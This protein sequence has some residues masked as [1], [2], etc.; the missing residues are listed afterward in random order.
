LFSFG[1]FFAFSFGAG[2]KPPKGFVNSLA[3][4][5]VRTAASVSVAAVL[6]ACLLDSDRGALPSGETGRVVFDLSFAQNKKAIGKVAAGA[7]TAFSLDTLVI[8]LTAPGEATIEDRIPVTGRP[9]TGVVTIAPRDYDLAALRNWKARF[10]TIDTT[11]SPVR[12]DT[13]HIDSVTFAV[14][15]DKVTEVVKTV[16]SAYSILRTRFLANVSITTAPIRFL[17][18]KVNGVTRDSFAFGEDAT[19]RS[20]TYNGV[21]FLKNG[22]TGYAV[23]DSGRIVKSLNGG[24]TWSLL[25]SG[26]NEDLKSV[27]FPDTINASTDTGYAVGTSGWILR[28]INGGSTWVRQAVGVTSRRLNKVSFVN[29][30]TG[31]AVGDSLTL[32][33]TTDAGVTWAQIPIPATHIRTWAT[34]TSGTTETLRSVHFTGLTEGVAVGDANVIRRTTTAGGAWS[35]ITPPGT[36]QLNSIRM[37]TAAVG[38]SVG[39]KGR[40]LLTTDNGATWAVQDTNRLTT[41]TLRSVHATAANA[42]MAVGDDET[43]LIAT[44]TNATNWR[45]VGGGWTRRKSGTTTSVNATHFFSAA[46]GWA[47]GGD[48]SI[49]RTTD[50]GWS[51]TNVGSADQGLNGIA[52]F[53]ATNVVAVGNNG[54]IRRTT[55]GTGNPPTWA[56]ITVAALGTS[57]ARGIA[58]VST[59]I[60]WMVADNG[61]Y[62]TAN[63]GSTWTQRR[64]DGWRAVSVGNNRIWVV[65]NGG[66]IRRSVDRAATTLFDDLV[67]PGTAIGTTNLRGVSFSTA[68]NNIGYVVGEG[69]LI[70]KTTNGTGTLASVTWTKQTVPA[71]VASETFV[72]VHFVSATVGYVVGES[73]AILKTTNGGT[74]WTLQYNPASPQAMRGVWAT[75]ATTAVAVGANGTIVK[76][77]RG[78]DLL[79]VSKA[80]PP[81]LN[82]VFLTATAATRYA[83]GAGGTILKTINTG[84]DW[85]EQTSG[86]SADLHGA[87]FVSADVGYTFGANGTILRTI[88]GG[89]NWIPLISDVGVT[90]RSGSFLD[91]AR[92]WVA[93]DGGVVLKTVDSGWT[94]SREGSGSDLGSHDYQGVHA[95]NADS[96]LVVGSSGAIRKT[97][98]ANRAFPS[99]S[100]NLYSVYFRPYAASIGFVVGDGGGTLK[101]ADAGA[102]WTQFGGAGT[103]SAR[104]RDIFVSPSG[105]N[106]YVVGDR[107]TYRWLSST[108]TGSWTFQSSG[109]RQNLNTVLVTGGTPGNA[110][111]YAAGDSGVIRANITGGP[112]ADLVTTL[113][114]GTTESLRSLRCRNTANICWVVGTNAT[115]ANTTNATVSPW[116]FQTSG[117]KLF[118]KLLTYKYLKPGVPTTV[119]LQ[120]I[121]TISPS[122]R[123]YQ[124][125][126]VITTGAGVDSTINMPMTRCGSPTP[127]CAN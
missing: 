51:W 19:G 20:V 119:T 95:F 96:A 111:I 22:T 4:F 27:V 15:P 90:L 72:G 8:I 70:A 76:T 89:T 91:A 67:P 74:T 103:L 44:T 7:D 17:R 58:N 97:N 33:K 39:E 29:G 118:D 110:S 93:G 109:T 31:Y 112:A 40:I 5:V 21:W 114:P 65:G 121:D 45:N 24:T 12:R 94:W 106:T 126:Q 50:S 48:G 26:T 37:G 113:V 55:T 46:A 3:R 127:A 99:A 85:T 41:S 82:G 68:D 9:D 77:V 83:V 92:G 78:G 11:T 100:A 115:L 57:V 123:G 107:G 25:N 32:L 86:T 116:T 47:V 79:A 117:T 98:N 60:G 75:T 124:A 73:G 105:N 52:A 84:I 88:N 42:V 62:S 63:S 16:S 54:R 13:I 30:A 71:A 61:I 122:L 53:S 87:Y 81:R 104:L 125:T 2:P 28:T 69:G 56:N 14:L 102:T 18:L 64:T 36:G 101:T 59:T 38:W 6:A 66:T 35:T 10:Y 80:V 108:S 49:L 23:G 1:P 34:Q 43:I 120:A